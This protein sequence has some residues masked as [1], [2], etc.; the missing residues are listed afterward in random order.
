M[1]FIK[2]YL[3]DFNARRAYMVAYGNPNIS[4]AG[5]EGCSTLKKPKVMY[6]I[7]KQIRERME[8]LDVKNDSIVAQLRDMVFM[9]A[10]QF[11]DEDDSYKNMMELNISQQAAKNLKVKTLRN[12]KV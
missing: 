4:T 9:D 3:K 2:E 5:V 1:L 8:K 6:E 11:Y 10:R 7:D 12:H